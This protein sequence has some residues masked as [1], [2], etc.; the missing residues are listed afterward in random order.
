MVVKI[1]VLFQ[2]EDHVQTAGQ[3]WDG[4]LH[5][6]QQSSSQVNIGKNKTKVT[7]LAISHTQKKKTKCFLLL[8]TQRKACTDKSHQAEGCNSYDNGAR[9]HSMEGI[10][11]KSPMQS[12]IPNSLKVKKNKIF[13]SK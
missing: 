13:F 12:T 4:H 11:H 8:L 7:L 2:M 9:V 10:P 1:H 6:Q 3:V 5:G